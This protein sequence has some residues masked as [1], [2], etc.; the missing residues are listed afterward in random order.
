[1]QLRIIT[2][3]AITAT[4]ALIGLAP[5]AKAAPTGCSNT[6]GATICQTPGNAQVTAQPGQ[7]AEDAARLQYPFFVF[8]PYGL[9]VRH[10]IEHG[11]RR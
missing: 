1:M 8:G 7:A 3:L 10:G 2:S 9:V 5:M 6:G 11:H 4:A